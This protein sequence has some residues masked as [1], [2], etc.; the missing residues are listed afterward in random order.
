MLA[1]DCLMIGTVFWLL[2]LS[3]SLK[4]ESF[5]LESS[6]A[7]YSL[8]SVLIYFL[9]D[10][11][12]SPDPLIFLLPDKTCESVFSL[13]LLGLSRTKLPFASFFLPDE[14]YDTT[15]LPSWTYCF[16]GLVLFN[17]LSSDSDSTMIAFS[18][19]WLAPLKLLSSDSSDISNF[20][21]VVFL[22][23]LLND[24]EDKL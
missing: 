16:K 14:I 8:K 4:D 3:D 23:R 7:R 9:S 15:F 24:S 17:S 12:L 20:L 6:K 19:C 21:L 10:F 11:S 1:K 5:A 18:F 13:M 22:G 2:L